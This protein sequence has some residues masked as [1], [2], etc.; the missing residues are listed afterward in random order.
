LR[1]AF[2]YDTAPCQLI[3]VRGA[4]FREEIVGKIKSFGIQPSALV[5]K[6][7]GRTA[8]RFV[9]SCR[10]DLLDLVLVLNKRNFKRLLSES[11]H[12]YHDR[13]HL[14]LYKQTRVKRTM[15]KHPGEGPEVISCPRLGDLHHCFDLA[16]PE[17]ILARASTVLE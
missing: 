13:T 2:P 8:W 14:V 10:R 12:H 5:S 7:R 4:N 11:V 15:A 9:G 1:E 17:F 6:A 3:F 16:C